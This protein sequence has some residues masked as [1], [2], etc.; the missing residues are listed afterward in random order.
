[1]TNR[2][3]AAGLALLAGDPADVAGAPSETDLELSAAPALACGL[4]LD[5]GSGSNRRQGV[6]SAGAGDEAVAIRRVRM[7][8]VSVRFIGNAQ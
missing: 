3:G 6:T 1:V 5:G 2:L 8:P 4:I 7:V